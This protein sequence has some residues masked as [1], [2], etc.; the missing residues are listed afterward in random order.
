MKIKYLFNNLVALLRTITIG[1][2]HATIVNIDIMLLLGRFTHYKLMVLE[3]NVTNERMSL[4]QG[5][6]IGRLNSVHHN[7][8]SLDSL[9]G[10]T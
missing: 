2:Y 7:S 3:S 4:I 8:A 6:T 5:D 9:F 1:Q 10:C